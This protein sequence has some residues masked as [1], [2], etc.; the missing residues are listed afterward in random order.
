MAGIIYSEGSGLNNSI[1]GKQL[2]PIR[3]VLNENAEAF[4]NKSMIHAHPVQ[5]RIR[6]FLPY[7][8]KIQVERFA[9]H[10]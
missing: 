8:D 5:M 10:K 9:I 1:I 7:T 6:R 2:A 4:E 3:A